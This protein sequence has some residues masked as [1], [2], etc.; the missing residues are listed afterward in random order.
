[1]AERIAKIIGLIFVVLISWRQI[2]VIPLSENGG[3][4]L[5]VNAAPGFR[6][7]IE[8]AVGLAAKCCRTCD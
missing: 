1:M 3:A 4:V 8:P 5:E 2:L 6:M 7:H